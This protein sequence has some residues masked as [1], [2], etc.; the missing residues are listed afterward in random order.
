[1]SWALHSEREAGDR[2]LVNA[3]GLT[4]AGREL[5]QKLIAR[6]VWIDLAHAS[7]ASA[8][9][10]LALTDAAGLPALITH[11]SLRRHLP[12][13]RAAPD[14]ELE[15]AARTGGVVGLVPSDEMLGNTPVSPESCAPGCSL[16]CAAGIHLLAAQYQ[17]LAG[18]VPAVAIG[19]GSDYSDGITHLRPTC[20]M[21]TS[22]DGRGLWNIGQAGDVW[23]SL[24]R[25]QAP[26]PRPRR[27]MVDHFIEAWSRVLPSR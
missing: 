11:T 14:W 17:E 12:A 26:V 27:A 9:D 3:Q 2:A 19:L 21:G 1:L 6:G 4:P 7:D 23:D 5:A 8:R 22:L 24:E 25:L 16:P 13:E 18:L 15:A 10:L 20:P